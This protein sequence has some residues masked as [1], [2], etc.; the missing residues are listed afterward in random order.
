VSQTTLC[1]NGHQSQDPEW[2]D[3]CGAR[4]GAAPAP[5]PT[6]QPP[7]SSAAPARPATPATPAIDCPHCG[8]PN[9]AGALFCEGCGYDFTTGQAPPTTEPTGAVEASEPPPA[10]AAQGWVVVVEVDPAW[11]ELKGQLADHPCPPVSS[12]T[13]ALT[14]STALIGRTSQ[15]KQLHPEIALDGDTGVSRRHAQLVCAAD[16][17]WTVVDLGSSNGTYV[18]PAGEA[19]SHDVEALPVGIPRPL[20][21][22]DAIYLGAWTKLTVRGPGG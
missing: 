17:S 5:V 16:G 4:L 22:R 10:P 9:E 7:D 13:I 1:P 6:S 21:D 3:T 11:Y 8:T 19:P 2:C 15:S 18:V 14:A 20:A 12:S